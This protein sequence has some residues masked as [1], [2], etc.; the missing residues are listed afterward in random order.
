MAVDDA[1]LAAGERQDSLG[2]WPLTLPFRRARIA[3]AVANKATPPLQLLRQRASPVRAET[4]RRRGGKASR[5]R[6]REAGIGR[7]PTPAA[8]R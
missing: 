5:L 1:V 3:V 6:P 7:G 2:A 8:G 4:A